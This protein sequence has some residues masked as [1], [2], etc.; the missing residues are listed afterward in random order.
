MPCMKR[1]YRDKKA[2]FHCSAARKKERFSSRC[3]TA[4]Q[5]RVNRSFRSPNRLHRNSFVCAS[6]ETFRRRVFDVLGSARKVCSLGE[7]FC[8]RTVLPD[9]APQLRRAP[10]RDPPVVCPGFGLDRFVPGRAL[11]EKGLQRRKG[12]VSLVGSQ[13]ERALLAPVINR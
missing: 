6:G 3:E 1:V 13:E 10:R 11:H 12:V 5:L 4:Y 8:W 7:Q 9:P 2:S